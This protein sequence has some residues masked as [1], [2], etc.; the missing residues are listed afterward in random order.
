M[1]F[2]D[3]CKTR[4]WTQL[5]DFLSSSI[6]DLSTK[7]LVTALIER[8]HPDQELAANNGLS[9]WDNK[10]SKDPVPPALA[11][12][13]SSVD[14]MDFTNAYAMAQASNGL[15]D[16]HV[17]EYIKQ[18]IVKNKLQLGQYLNSDRIPDATKKTIIQL[19]GD[20]TTTKAEKEAWLQQKFA[21]QAQEKISFILAVNEVKKLFAEL[22][23][24]KPYEFQVFFS[25]PDSSWNNSATLNF[26]IKMPDEVL[27][28]R[29]DLLTSLGINA[30]AGH[31]GTMFSRMQVA[32][33]AK[34]IQSI[35]FSE[36]PQTIA[37][38]LTQ[39][40]CYRVENK[41]LE[42]LIQGQ[43]TEHRFFK[44]VTA[45]AALE[46]SPSLPLNNLN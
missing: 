17:A 18:Y 7:I 30:S 40:Q 22:F 45:M 31:I 4:E 21:E 10:L 19:L 46:K 14:L 13:N 33:G 15:D 38:L 25:R 23:Q 9:V 39:F 28:Q 24:L 43:S 42:P 27:Q 34:E 5:I 41:H 16:P 20:L 44:A 8:Y 12:L 11:M 2:I 3:M 26:N 6:K 36:S 29:T 37:E 1:T 35:H 32:Q